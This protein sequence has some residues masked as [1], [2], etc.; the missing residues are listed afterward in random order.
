VDVSVFVFWLVSELVGD[1]KKNTT[2][3]SYG[4]SFMEHSLVKIMLFV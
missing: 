1:S 2:S 3:I 4:K